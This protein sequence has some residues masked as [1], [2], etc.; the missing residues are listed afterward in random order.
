MAK[1]IRRASRPAS[2]Q[3]RKTDMRRQ[4]LSRAV[5]DPEFRRRLFRNPEEVFEGRLSKADAAALER[6]KVTLPALV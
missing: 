2:E 3:T 4:I 6:M 1:P 5:V